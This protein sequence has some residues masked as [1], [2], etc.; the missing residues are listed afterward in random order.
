ME[1]SPPPPSRIRHRTQCILCAPLDRYAPPLRQLWKTDGRKRENTIGL[2]GV[3]LWSECKRVLGYAESRK[4]KK[5]EWAS[6]RA[7]RNF[8]RIHRQRPVQNIRDE[9][10]TVVSQR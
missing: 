8:N 9:Q 3:S 4:G 7:Y 6:I 5:E 10:H 1:S 2:S